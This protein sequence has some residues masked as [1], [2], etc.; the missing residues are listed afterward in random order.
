MRHIKKKLELII[1]TYKY[2][3]IVRG[4]TYA[5]KI[6]SNNKI[7]TFILMH[8][9]Y[10]IHELMGKGSKFIHALASHPKAVEH[11]FL[12]NILAKDGHCIVHAMPCH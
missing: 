12:H 1:N 11:F 2:S 4:S 5:L 8:F 10:L 6:N 9:Y 3:S 7:K